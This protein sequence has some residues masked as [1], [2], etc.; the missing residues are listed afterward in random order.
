MRQTSGG[1]EVSQAA[2][3]ARV[4]SAP[5]VSSGRHSP[6][7][8]ACVDMHACMICVCVYVCAYVCVCVRSTTLAILHHYF[9]RSAMPHF[10]F[11][12]IRHAAGGQRLLTASIHDGIADSHAVVIA[13]ERFAQWLAM[14]CIARI[15]HACHMAP[16]FDSLCHATFR[17]RRYP[18]CG[19]WSALAHSFFT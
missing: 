5:V 12:S 17:V 10:V 9:T 15:C 11:A 1:F 8:T 13:Q 19:R 16:L 18:T 7:K 4:F 2:W 6:Q 3:Y 14:T